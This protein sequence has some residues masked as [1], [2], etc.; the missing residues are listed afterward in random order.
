MGYFRR[1]ITQLYNDQTI[2]T[3]HD[4]YLDALYSWERTIIKK[5]DPNDLQKLLLEVYHTYLDKKSKGKK[6]PAWVKELK[7]VDA[8]DQIDTNISLKEISKY[9]DFQMLPICQENFLN[10]LITIFGDY[11]RKQRIESRH[12]HLFQ[13][14]DYTLTDIAYL[15]ALAIK[16]IL[17]VF[18]KSILAK[19]LQLTVKHL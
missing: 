8:E 14:P 13:N 7:G 4:T 16:A 12:I 10:I 2:A 11:L 18:L 6:T 17:R 9:L 15:T 3:R 5:Q 19:T 1:F